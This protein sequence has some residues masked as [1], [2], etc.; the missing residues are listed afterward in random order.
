MPVYGYFNIRKLEEENKEFIS[1]VLDD[2]EI[3]P[4]AGAECSL[5]IDFIEL[6]CKNGYISSELNNILQNKFDGDPFKYISNAD[7]R[8]ICEQKYNLKWEK[9]VRYKVCY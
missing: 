6:S 9:E 5:L 7:F 8:K 2:L 4:A 3:S 1:K